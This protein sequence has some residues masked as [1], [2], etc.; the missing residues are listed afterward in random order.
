MQKLIQSLNSSICKCTSLIRV[1]SFPASSTKLIKE[2]RYSEMRFKIDKRISN[3]ALI[4]K[5]NRQIEKIIGPCKA[6]IYSR[7]NHFFCIFVRDIF[8]HDSCPKIFIFEYLLNPYN[9]HL[10]F[11]FIQWFLHRFPTVLFKWGLPAWAFTAVI[12][13]VKIRTCIC[14]FG[15]YVHIHFLTQI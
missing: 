13:R 3:I 12:V 4:F 7:K 5:V 15:A 10:L 2:R 11:I 8:N 1:E 6:L 9:T 14:A